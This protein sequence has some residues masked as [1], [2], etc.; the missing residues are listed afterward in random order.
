MEY[1][2]EKCKMRGFTTTINASQLYQ[3]S[4]KPF[5]KTFSFL[6]FQIPWMTQHHAVCITDFSHKKLIFSY[7]SRYLATAK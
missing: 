7:L 1:E 3:I 6:V 4:R 2:E 5:Q